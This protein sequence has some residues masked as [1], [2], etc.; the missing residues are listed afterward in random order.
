MINRLKKM[1]LSTKVMFSFIVI[2]LISVGSTALVSFVI[3]KV[4]VEEAAFA[5]L[6]SVRE[7]QSSQVESYFQ[8]IRDQVRT[9]SEDRMIVSAMSEFQQAFHAREEG[10][11]SSEEESKEESTL[12]NFYQVNFVPRYQDG[13]GD[14]DAS[15]N[16]FW[17]GDKLTTAFQ[18]QY[19]ARNPNPLGEKDS[20]DTY[21]DGS[22]YSDV[23][24]KY[25]PIIRNFQQTFGYYDIFLV[26][27]ET[28]H[29]VYSVFKEVDFATS[30]ISGPYRQ[31]NFADAFRSARQGQSAD[32]VILEDF[33]SYAPVLQ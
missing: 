11:T 17:P 12:R 18:Y 20:L 16:Q 25:H 31:T 15:T 26:D 19:L 33:E 10:L 7:L 24:A 21:L 14:D 5:H 3:A 22:I 4:A 27:A 6:T 1:T 28:G 8:N 2:A 32:Y 13:S 29:I 23:H 9:F 30:L